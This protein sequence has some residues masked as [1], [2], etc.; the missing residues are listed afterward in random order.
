MEINIEKIKQIIKMYVPKKDITKK[1]DIIT[2]YRDWRVV[3]AVFLSLNILIIAS[4]FYLF[5]KINK[6]EI[7]LL[8]NTGLVWV[9]RID[10]GKLLDAVNLYEQREDEFQSLLRKRPQISDPSL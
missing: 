6:E 2:V 4:S 10:K 3:V 9:D 5:V 8:E 7:F 1:K